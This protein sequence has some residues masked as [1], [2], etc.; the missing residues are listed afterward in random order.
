MGDA[1]NLARNR[2]GCDAVKL[3]SSCLPAE[4]FCSGNLARLFQHDGYPEAP[5]HRMG[6][7]RIRGAGSPHARCVWVR[8]PRSSS[9]EHGAIV[10]VALSAGRQRVGTLIFATCVRALLERIHRRLA[11][12]VKSRFRSS[13]QKRIG[14][15]IYPTGELALADVAAHIQPHSAPTATSG[16]SVRSSA[17]SLTSQRGA[18]FTNGSDLHPP[19][20]ELK[21][22]P[23]P[24]LRPAMLAAFPSVMPHSPS[25]PHRDGGERPRAESAAN[26]QN[27]RSG[28]HELTVGRTVAALGHARVQ[29]I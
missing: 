5:R 19:R 4:G 9:P 21:H 10:L 1:A 12:A 24:A 18:V 25:R 11:D 27:E 29:E 13:K 16:A 2:D 14:K 26:P 8:C 22:P 17:R 23:N 15:H 28:R 7:G 3:D 6:Y 20:T